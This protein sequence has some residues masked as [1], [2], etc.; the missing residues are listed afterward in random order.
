MASF[1]VTFRPPVSR[2]AGRVAADRFGLPPFIDGSCRREPDLE[3]AAPGVSALCRGGNFAPRLHT[4]DTAVYLTTKRRWSGYPESF[5]EL[6]SA[7]AARIC[8]ASTGAT[9]LDVGRVHA[10]RDGSGT[11][12]W[13][14]FASRLSGIT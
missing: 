6:A 14:P 12:G 4:G 5:E 8:F 3:S 13:T 9:A 2:R 7:T 11:F 1:L 10:V